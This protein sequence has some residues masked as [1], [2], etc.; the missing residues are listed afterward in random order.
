ML[1][2]KKPPALSVRRR[3]TRRK[4]EITRADLQRNCQAPQGARLNLWQ[5]SLL[6]TSLRRA[7][8]WRS[9]NGARERFNELCHESAVE[10]ES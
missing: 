8:H 3:L 6:C 9:F 4:G 1:I 5:V 2:K 7:L 10:G